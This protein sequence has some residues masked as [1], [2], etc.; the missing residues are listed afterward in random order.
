[1]D[2]NLAEHEHTCNQ[3]SNAKAIAR[4]YAKLSCQEPGCSRIFW[5]L[6][7]RAQHQKEHKFL[8]TACPDGCDPDEV[9]R[10][11]VTLK[12][13]Q[14]MK[15]RDGWP[16]RCRYRGC[17]DEK[18]YTGETGYRRH[19]HLAYGLDTTEKQTPYRP[20]TMKP[21]FRPVRCP[22]EDCSSCTM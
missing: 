9:Y 4:A 10:S 18:T 19:L 8:E 16:T 20:K 5:S 15:H 2:W 13:H 14:R 7:S 17:M 22:V 11:N 1:M 12:Y 3:K 6:K 21:I